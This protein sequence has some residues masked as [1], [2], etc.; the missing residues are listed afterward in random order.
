MKVTKRGFPGILKDNDKFYLDFIT[1][2]LKHSDPE[3]EILLD[4]MEDEIKV[5][6]TP[7][8]PAFR[9]HIIDNLLGAHRLFKIKIIFSKSLALEKRVNFLVENLVNQ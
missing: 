9:Q 1:D 6:V 5:S 4:K 2:A 7:S 8:E 3:A